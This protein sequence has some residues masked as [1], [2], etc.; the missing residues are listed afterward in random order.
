MHKYGIVIT[1]VSDFRKEPKFRSERVHQVV[2][3]EEVEILSYES[4][5]EYIFVKDLRISYTGYINRNSLTLL[6]EEEF[7]QYNKHSVIKVSVPFVKTEGAINYLLPFGSRL[8]ICG[9]EFLLPDG[10]VF[11]ALDEPVKRFQNV[12]ECTEQFLGVPYLWGGTSSYGFDC[13]GLT[14]R[15]YDIFGMDIP[16]D[17]QDQEKFC[18]TKGLAIDFSEINPGDLIFMKGHVMI[19]YGDSKVIHANGKYMCVTINDLEKEEYGRYLKSAI[20]S[21]GRIKL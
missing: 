14:N 17:A 9:N 15:V 10:R 2:F 4:D 6:T 5:S 20:T 21:V 11:N 1:P 12:I 7:E 3:G 13:S 16:R 19:Y 18:K 8:R